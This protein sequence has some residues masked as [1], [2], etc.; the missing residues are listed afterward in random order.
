M[1]E[2]IFVNISGF[3]ASPL[4]VHLDPN[5]F[6]DTKEFKVPSQASINELANAANVAT[7]TTKP[8]NLKLKLCHIIALSP[9]LAKTGIAFTSKTPDELIVKFIATIKAFDTTHATDA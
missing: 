8:R 5:I 7:T 6:Y 9:F 2:T 3:G 1:P 4:A